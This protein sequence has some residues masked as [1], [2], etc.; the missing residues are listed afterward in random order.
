MVVCK[1]KMQSYCD[2]HLLKKCEVT[3]EKKKKKEES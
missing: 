2:N 1:D 3:M